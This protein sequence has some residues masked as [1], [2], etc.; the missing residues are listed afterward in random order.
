MGTFSICC[1]LVY[2]VFGS[3]NYYYSAV[4]YLAQVLLSVPR[5]G[6]MFVEPEIWRGPFKEK[7]CK[8]AI[9]KLDMKVKF[10]R[11]IKSQEVIN[12]LKEG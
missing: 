12:F 7:E 1:F 2:S 9:T 5:S 3:S 6:S 4:F 8:R 10:F 11:M